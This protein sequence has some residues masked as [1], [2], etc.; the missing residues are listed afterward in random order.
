MVE[1][2]LDAVRFCTDET[3]LCLN[4][5]F[6]KSPVILATLVASL[7]ESVVLLARSGLAFTA[8][9]FASIDCLNWLAW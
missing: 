9:V 1:R 4:W 8:S 7:I 5:L 6:W 3:M 2:L